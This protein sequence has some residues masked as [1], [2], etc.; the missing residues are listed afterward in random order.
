[1]TSTSGKWLIWTPRILLTAFA[2]FLGIFSLDV[3]REGASASEIAMGLFLH[4]LPSLSLFVVVAVA[5]RWPWFGTFACVALGLVYIAW[6]W[7]KFP[8]SVY[9]LIAGPLFVIATLY[10]LDGRRRT[11]G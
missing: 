11:G 1:M 3:F 6:A 2:L 10:A 4:N 5:W 9:L 8:F 7:G